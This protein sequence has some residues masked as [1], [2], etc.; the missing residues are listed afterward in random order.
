MKES[1]T[2]PKQSYQQVFREL[3]QHHEWFNSSIPLIASENVPSLAVREAI[4]SDFG[5]RYAEGWPGERV[6]AGC[7]YIDKVEILCTELARRLFKA[8]FADVRPI[9]GVCANLSVYTAFTSPGDRILSLSIPSGGHIST[10]KAEFG[11]T[12]GS[13]RGLNVEY[14]PFDIDNMNIDV[15][16]TKQKVADL[17]Q[18]TAPKLSLAMFGGSVLLFPQPLKELTEFFH[19]HQIT[20]CFDAAHVLGLIAGGQFQDPLREGADIM[21]AST[22]KTLPGPQ[23]GV[24]LSWEKFAE[25]IKKSVF[26]ANLSNHHLHHVAGK[27]IA[28]T[29]MM[30]FGKEYAE[31]V[32]MNARA[33][34][35]SLSTRGFKVLGESQGFTRSHI[36]IA[37]ISQYGNGKEIEKRLEGANII[38]NRNLLPYDIKMGRHFETPGG[39]RCGTSECTRLGMRESEMDEIA[40]LISQVVVKDVS[41]QKSRER[42]TEFRKGFTKIKFCFE[43]EA[44]A[45]KYIRLRV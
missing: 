39:I 16:K 36:V 35:T 19:D 44:E 10:G 45:Y 31:Q 38:L 9:S 29:E 37:D 26:P 1:P 7:T 12:A 18:G 11:G 33:L 21:T 3:Q 4:L 20:V 24:I 34:A 25:R 17:T 23:G 43:S 27:A 8:E 15:D 13:V 14:F 28:F 2:D 32:V 41:Q 6:Y 5:N 42:V 40:D 22:H 30:A